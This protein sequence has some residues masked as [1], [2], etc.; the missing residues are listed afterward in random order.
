MD[1]KTAEVMLS[2][3]INKL[4]DCNIYMHHI[5]GNSFDTA[6][7][8]RGYVFKSG[9]KVRYGRSMFFTL[10]PLENPTPDELIDYNFA[11]KFN[12]RHL[13]I[14]AVP[15]VTHI[16][17]I[18]VPFSNNIIPFDSSDNIVRNERYLSPFDVS[19]TL[20]PNK[21]IPSEFVFGCIDIDGEEVCIELNKNFK[22]NSGV[23]EYTKK[24][25]NDFKIERTDDLETINFKFDSKLAEMN[26][27]VGERDH[28]NDIEFDTEP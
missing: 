28:F 16:N 15:K 13:V 22:P 21:Y 12:K 6:E 11:G 17:D 9:I 18:M 20:S 5:W 24:I 26:G 25:V 1:R 10:E 14:V 7:E 23:Q 27:D 2:V 19:R 8:I 3:L 4:T